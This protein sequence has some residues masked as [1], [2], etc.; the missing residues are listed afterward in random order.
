M[1]HKPKTIH[2]KGLKFDSKS[3]ACKTPYYLRVTG[4][5]DRPRPMDRKKYEKNYDK[6]DWGKK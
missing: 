3:K 2:D 4:R 6:I 1:R 5:G